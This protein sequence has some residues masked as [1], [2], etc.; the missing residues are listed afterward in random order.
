L[1]KAFGLFVL[2]VLAIVAVGE[3][4][5]SLK[6]HLALKHARQEAKDGQFMRA[7]FWTERALSVDR[8]NVDAVRL[9]A[10]INEA[11]D[12]PVALEWRARVAQLNPSNATD[13]LAWAKCAFRFGQ[14]DTALKALNG[15]PPDFQNR[16]ADYQELMAGYAI[17]DHHDALAEADF[18]RAAELDPANPIH[19]TNLAAFRLNYSANPE[20][21]AA[22]GKEL[23]GMVN[24][25]RAALFAVR[26]LLTEA[27]RKKDRAQMRQWAEKLRT[28]PDRSFN[29]DLACLESLIAEPSFPA[30]L[31]EI[32]HR[33]EADSQWVT[34]TGDWLNRH[35]KVAETLRW[36]PRLPEPIRFNVRVQMTTAEGY[37]AVRDWKGLQSFLTGRQWE[38]GEFLRRAMLVRCERELSQPWEKD[39]KQLVDDLQTRQPDGFLLA[40][41]ILGWKWRDEALTLFWDAASQPKTNSMALESLWDLYSQTKD[42]HQLLRVAKAQSEID[43]SSPA[44]KNNEAFLTLLLFGASERAERLAREATAV[45][46]KIPEWAATYAYALHLAGKNEEAG[47]VLAS[48]PPEALARPGIALYEAIVLAANHD[49]ARAKETLARLNAHGM[50]PE[51]QKLAADLAQQLN[52]VSR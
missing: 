36:F 28:L 25:P 18:V 10:E 8:K 49:T 33:A 16:S 12:R 52:L 14:R 41:L 40:Q 5:R 26:A 31:E 42:T 7:E 6:L 50:L 3:G 11:Q 23:E 17:A 51:E 45:N 19:R 37:Q 44:K 4:Y 21:R 30:A 27:I 32:E 20:V 13:I 43:P 2:L 24:D 35:G 46:P 1:S 47:K 39:W 15:L 9:M 48:L 38:D 22:A 29:D 34:A